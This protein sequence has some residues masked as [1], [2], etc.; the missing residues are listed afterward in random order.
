MSNLENIEH[1]RAKEAWGCIDYVNSEET[2][3]FKK[4]YRSIVMKTPTLIITN[5]LG[6][7]LAFLKSKGKGDESK[8]EDKLYRDIE[9]W[10]NKKV[11]WTAKGELMEKIISL[12][13]DKF[14]YTT[15]ET[16]SF[17]SWMKRFADAVL[18]KEGD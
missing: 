6:Q 14:R 7:T 18:P 10:L 15:A 2:D 16:L 8:P 9:G 3:K 11:L 5:G 4:E 17:L 1:E 12:P 13:N